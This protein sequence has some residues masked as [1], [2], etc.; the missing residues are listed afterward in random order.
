[1][2]KYM[3]KI[4]FESE[5]SVEAIEVNEER[6]TVSQVLALIALEQTGGLPAPRN[7]NRLQYSIGSSDQ[8]PYEVALYAARNNRIRGMQPA[9]AHIHG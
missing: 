6:L 1:M 8:L 9:R 2:N 7:I 5:P 4:H 3:P